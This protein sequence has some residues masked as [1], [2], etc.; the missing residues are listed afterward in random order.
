MNY[1]YL[2]DKQKKDLLQEH[3]AEKSKSF[4]DISKEYDTYSNKLRRDA[5]KFNIK[6]RTKSEAQSN[7]LKTGKSKHPTKGKER[8]TEVKEKIGMSVLKS[9][10]N[11]DEA[12][13]KKRKEDSKTRWEKL[14]DLKKEEMLT[15]ANAAV[16]LTS[17]NGSKLEKYILNDLLAAGF[18]VEFHKEQTLSNTKLQLDLFLPEIGLAIEVDGPSH[19]EPVWGKDSLEKNKKYDNKKNG[20]IIGKG[21][22]LVRV[23][24]TKDFSPSR[25]KIICNKIKE[26]INN[27]SDIKD[28]KTITI[29]DDNASY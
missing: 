17:K 13:L 5:I 6:I 19:F 15:Q 1:E 28:T 27:I 11:L 8:G 4:A 12:S 9:W 24:Q 3:Y 29:G 23:K 2:S 22:F 7:A 25:A 14:D 20:L 21:L 16:R 10:E 18:R 26:V